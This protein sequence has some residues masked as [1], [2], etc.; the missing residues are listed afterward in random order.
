MSLEI[1]SYE[2]MRKAEDASRSPW[3]G[4][5]WSA[6]Y[7]K[8]KQETRGLPIQQFC[9]RVVDLYKN[10]R[11]IVIEAST[12]SGKSTQ[13]TKI[14]LIIEHLLKQ[15]TWRYIVATSPRRV[16]TMSLANG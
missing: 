11:A 1:A 8:L 7:R 15:K 9:E 16:A 12:G 10:N 13:V 6:N 3:T 2:E 5:P 14:I 4:K